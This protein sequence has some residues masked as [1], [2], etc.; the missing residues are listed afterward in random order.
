MPIGD[1][2]SFTVEHATH[3]GKGGRYLSTSPYAAAKKAARIL[4][5]KGQ[6]EKLTLTLRETTIGADHAKLFKYHATLHKLA[7][8]V[9]LKLPGNKTVTK[10]FEILI[11]SAK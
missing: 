9:V 4:F 5:A 7:K 2:R 11:K 10:R 8:P 3:G 6:V 1:R